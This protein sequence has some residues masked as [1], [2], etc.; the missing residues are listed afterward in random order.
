MFTEKPKERMLGY[1]ET[2]RNRR[3]EVM[4]LDILGL[5]HF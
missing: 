5:E 2:V 1:E 3:E 4:E